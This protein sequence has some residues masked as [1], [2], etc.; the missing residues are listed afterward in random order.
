MRAALSLVLCAALTSS[1]WGAASRTLEL[2]P[3]PP[4]W[5]AGFTAAA[6]WLTTPGP[7]AL[8][9]AVDRDLLDLRLA[10][11]ADPQGLQALSPLHRSLEARL[12][13]AE[14]R[15]RFL[16]RLADL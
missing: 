3:L 8:A 10:A 1:S 11:A 12:G 15:R 7:A 6:A 4:A 9:A 5:A 16:S 13:G 14:A 2:S